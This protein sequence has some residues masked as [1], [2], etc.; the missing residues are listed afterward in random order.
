MSQKLPVS[1][2]KWKKNKSKFTEEFIKNYDE[3]GNKGEKISQ[4]LLK[5]L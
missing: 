3:D 1:S 5:S 2:F 4:N